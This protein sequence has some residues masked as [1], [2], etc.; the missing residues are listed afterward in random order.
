MTTT[1]NP[2]IVE[3]TFNTPVNVI[4][5]AITEL[6]QMHQWFFENIPDF[7]PEVGFKTQF[8]VHSGERNF[9]HLWKITTVKPQKK[10]TYNWKY[11]NYEGDSFVHFE[12]F[13]QKS[14]SML[15]ITT[16]IIENFT[17]DIPE[18]KSENCRAGWE[19]F[20]QKNLKAYL[21]KSA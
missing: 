7:K 19:Y 13:E 8:N 20:I 10:I 17:A 6:D 12:L 14:G 15:R 5:K 9:M 3:Q 16:E 11:E 2:I 1:D 18:F 21:E 4:W